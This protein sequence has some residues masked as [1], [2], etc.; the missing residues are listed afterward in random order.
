MRVTPHKRTWQFLTLFALWCGPA[1]SEDISTNICDRERS[2][3]ARAVLR[4]VRRE[5]T[6]M[7]LLMHYNRSRKQSHTVCSTSYL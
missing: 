5:Q 3:A 4:Q 6:V 1:V 2:R 7:S